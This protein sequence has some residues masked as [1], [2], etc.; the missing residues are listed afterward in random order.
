MFLFYFQNLTLYSDMGNTRNLIIGAILVLLCFMGCSSYNGMATA[1]QAVKKE[2]GEV[3]NQFQRRNDLI[4]NLVNTVKGAADFEQG[5][6]T[7]VIEARSKASQIKVDP[8]DLSPEN[9]EKFQQAQGQ[10]G[11]VMSRLMVLTENYPTLRATEQFKGLSDELAGTE[12]RIAVA[13]GRF[14]QVVGDFNTRVVRFPG[15]IFAGMFGFKEKGYFKADEGANKA[16][17]VD[18]GKK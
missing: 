18:F 13:R 9:I 17:T 1:D 11:Q 16:P 15:N 4:G 6:L 2:W 5:A 10:L 12:N 7:A 3:E 14:N 8:N